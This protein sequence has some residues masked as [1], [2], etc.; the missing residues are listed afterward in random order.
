MLS[1]IILA[2]STAASNAGVIDV[3]NVVGICSKFTAR[4]SAITCSANSRTHRSHE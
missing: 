2:A 3:I 1:K 4:Y